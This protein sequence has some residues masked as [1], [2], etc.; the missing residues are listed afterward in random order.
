MKV[1]LFIL[2]FLT[3]VSSFAHYY[4][5]AEAAEKNLFCKTLSNIL[6]GSTGSEGHPSPP[7][8]IDMDKCLKNKS[9]YSCG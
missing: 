2:L 4:E 3:R 1:L 6:S 5:P 9:I 8:V 7:L